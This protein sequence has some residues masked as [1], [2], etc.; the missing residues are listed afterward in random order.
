MME[1]INYIING[2]CNKM[3]ETTDTVI[4]L[5]TSQATQ[6][7]GNRLVVAQN[8]IDRLFVSNYISVAEMTDIIKNELTVILDLSEQET[9]T[10]LKQYETTKSIVDDKLKVAQLKQALSKIKNVD[11]T[12][13]KLIRKTEIAEI[14]KNL[15]DSK[16][17]SSQELL[18]YF[19]MKDLCNHFKLSYDEKEEIYKEVRRWMRKKL[20]I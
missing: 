5:A 18:H 17:I 16:F 3:E 20:K 7:D 14:S 13:T 12:F 19:I 11:D 4:H 6:G 15:I 8:I 1:C 10:L 9:E 2:W